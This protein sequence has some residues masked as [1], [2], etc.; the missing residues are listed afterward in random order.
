MQTSR[1]PDPSR[2]VRHAILNGLPVPAKEA[3]V[4]E[5]RGINV[6]EVEYRLRQMMGVR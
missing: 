2:I 5:A 3:A 6:S 1:S 4:L